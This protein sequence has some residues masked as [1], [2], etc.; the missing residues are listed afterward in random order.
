[1]LEYSSTGMPLAQHYESHCERTSEREQA[2]KWRKKGVLLVKWDMAIY[3]QFI[4]S[5]ET[6]FASQDIPRP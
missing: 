2:K 4:D 1:M 6:K 5:K 3:T